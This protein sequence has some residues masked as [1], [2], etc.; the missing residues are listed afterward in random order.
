MASI[1]ENMMESRLRWFGHV[2][3]R[4]T[5]APVRR[6]ERLARD[7]FKRGRDRA[8]QYCGEVIRHDM[9]LLQLIVDMTLDWWLWRTHISVGGRLVRCAL[10]L[11]LVIVCVFLTL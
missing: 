8:K 2:Q 3:R 4:C 9:Q 6:C 7:D 10:S 1:E 11:S 5:D